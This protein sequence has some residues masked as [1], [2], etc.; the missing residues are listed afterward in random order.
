[1]EAYYSRFNAVLRIA[2]PDGQKLLVYTLAGILGLNG[3][4]DD[5]VA[6]AINKLVARDARPGVIYPFVVRKCLEQKKIGDAFAA[7]AF[8]GRAT[9]M[10]YQ[11]SSAEGVAF[12]LETSASRF[13]QLNFKNY[14][15]HANHF[16]HPEMKPLEEPGWL[17]HGGS[18]VRVEVARDF[19]EDRLGSL[20]VQDL[21]TLCRDH[22]NRPNSICAHGYPGEPDYLSYASIAA[23]VFEP[24]KGAMHFCG[25]Y[26]C[27]N[28][29]QTFTFNG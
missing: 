13:A 1:M 16:F 22:V 12:C 28:A 26:P 23:V 8:C 18:Y 9:A 24:R 2:K 4:N 14:L 5:G 29:F 21:E 20:R 15:V 10:N 3:L 25:A 6:L 17:T 7:V 19:L 27:Q 11:L